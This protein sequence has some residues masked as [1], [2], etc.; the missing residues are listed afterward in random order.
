MKR[1]SESIAAIKRQIRDYQAQ[2]Q[3]GLEHVD[4]RLTTAREL[5][6]S[7]Y[8]A[9]VARLSKQI[10]RELFVE[11]TVDPA[12]IG[13]LIVQVGDKVLDGSVVRQLKKYNEVMTDIDVKKIGV[14][15]AV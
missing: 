6:G 3:N 12:I 9:I 15:N 4:I 13:G 5:D 1:H 14:T 10:G 11:K 7:E 8:D 2:P